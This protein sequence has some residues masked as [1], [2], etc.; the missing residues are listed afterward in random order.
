MI[1]VVASAELFF[2]ED[3]TR[4]LEKMVDVLDFLDVEEGESGSDEAPKIEHQRKGCAKM[5]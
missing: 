2:G 5:L 3:S 1:D 4:P